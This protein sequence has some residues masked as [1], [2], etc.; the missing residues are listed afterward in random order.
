M[1][2][3]S[4]LSVSAAINGP[5][6]S[7]SLSDGNAEGGI[8]FAMREAKNTQTIGADGS[9]MNSL[10]A[11]N[12]GTIT[13]RVLKTSPLNAMLSEMY[14]S[15]KADP[16]LWGNNVITLRDVNRGDHATG[17]GCAFQKMPDLSWDKEGPNV[18][19]VMD[20]GNIDEKL[21]GN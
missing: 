21:G 14:A 2:T 19:W 3:Y 11:G 10:H 15:D 1:A 9:V 12:A 6:G 8:S 5:N 20:A 18:E 16:T 4:F 13:I 7:F 17:T